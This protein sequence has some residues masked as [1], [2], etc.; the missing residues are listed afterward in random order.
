M[1]G[2]RDGR[3][4]H[5]RRH[6]QQNDQGTGS[7]DGQVRTGQQ[8]DRATPVAVLR[9]RARRGD[10]GARAELTARGITVA[11]GSVTTGRDEHARRHPRPA[12]DDTEGSP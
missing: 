7:G 3:A 12:D 11:T 6:G 10:A 8:G 9:K 4:E 2:V 5:Q 1:S